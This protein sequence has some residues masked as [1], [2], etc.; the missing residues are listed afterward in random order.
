MIA[1]ASKL[2]HVGTTIFTVMTQRANE[3]GA[4]NL[5]QGFPNFDAPE[6]LR[7]LVAEHVA[8]GHNQYAPM[9]GVEAL[10]EQIAAK[11]ERSYERRIDSLNEVTITLGATE[12]IFSAILALVHAGDEV[13]IFDPSYDSYAPAIAIAGGKP[14]HIPLQPPDFAID[15]QRVRETITARTRLII[16][17][18]PH[19]PATSI[20]SADDLTQLANLVRDTQILLL[21]DEVYEHIVFDGMRHHSI[22]GHAELAERTVGVYSFGK[23]MHATGWRVGYTIAAPALTR[24]I[25]RVHQ[26]NTFTIT[27]PL[28]HAIAD[29][30]REAPEHCAGL[31]A[32]YQAKRDYFLERLKGS[33]FA[34][35]P[36]AGTYFQLLDYREIAS[37]GD[38]EFAERLI[39]E[40][41]VAAIPLSPFYAEPPRLPY[42][43]FCFAKNE[44]TLEQAAERLSKL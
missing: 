21:A 10:R 31:S 4:I 11:F 28:Q 15:W 36:A 5:S 9:I 13:I 23:S 14:V 35:A 6:R 27:T 40:A 7:T 12:G 41:G 29:Y 38:M 22:C 43:R 37:Q 44:A 24:E 33:R 16:L 2:P 8:A 18:T 34:F 17:N 3:T 30:L 26:F 42:L 25:R 20:L 32:F 39:S 19:N 1:V